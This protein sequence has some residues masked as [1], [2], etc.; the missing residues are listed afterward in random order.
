L[1]SEKKKSLIAMPY[2]TH[3]YQWTRT[4]RIGF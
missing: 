4:I 1:N 3:P 2:Q